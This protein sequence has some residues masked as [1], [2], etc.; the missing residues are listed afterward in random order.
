MPESSLERSALG[1]PAAR[2]HL[3]LYQYIT[4]N[5]NRAQPLP[6]YTTYFLSQNGPFESL[7]KAQ[8]KAK[9]SSGHDSVKPRQKGFSDSHPYE[10][11]ESGWMAN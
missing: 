5:I 2:R 1:A 7:C 9:Q 4:K 3:V 10:S 6:A 8:A 11:I